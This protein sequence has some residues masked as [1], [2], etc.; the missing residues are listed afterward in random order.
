LA[1]GAGSFLSWAF[2]ASAPILPQKLLRHLRIAA[3]WGK[4]LVYA[5]LTIFTE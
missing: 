3:I 2:L 1:H 5:F 4:P